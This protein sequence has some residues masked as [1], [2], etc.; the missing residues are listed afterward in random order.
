MLLQ[1]RVRTRLLIN[2]FFFLKYSF[3]S[4]LWTK[5]CASKC[6]Q[7]LEKKRHANLRSTFGKGGQAGDDTARAHRVDRSKTKF[8][9][10][11]VRS[12]T[13]R[14][15]AASADG[16]RG[17]KRC[18]ET[19][20]VWGKGWNSSSV[21]RPI[22]ALAQ[23]ETPT[24]GEGS[25]RATWLRPQ[26][27]KLPKVESRA[28]V[29]LRPSRDVL[30]SGVDRKG[31]LLTTSWSF[32]LCQMSLRLPPFVEGGWT[33][34]TIQSENKSR[35]AASAARHL[36]VGGRAYPLTVHRVGLFLKDTR[37][38]WSLSIFYSSSLIKKTNKQTKVHWIYI[39]SFIHSGLR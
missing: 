15:N 12:I 7:I 18:P 16:R 37:W 34:S 33:S 27:T 3:P 13:D 20:P 10:T 23:S 11:N 24:M 26:M 25:S 1:Q 29:L 35:V 4:V 31:R 19:D 21:R 28:A 17:T 36:L 2:T 6:V 38:T 39:F 5:R 14:W 32:N 22:G 30:V 9:N 8:S